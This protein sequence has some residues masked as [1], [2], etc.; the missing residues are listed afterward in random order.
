MK[1]YKHATEVQTLIFD[2][3]LYT[4]KR[5]KAW[6]R[7]HKFCYGS[8][9]EKPNTIRLRQHDPS[10]YRPSTFRTI[11]LG[12]GGVRA[13]VGVPLRAAAAT[14]PAGYDSRGPRANPHV[15]TSRA[16]GIVKLAAKGARLK[17]IKSWL[18]LDERGTWEQAARKMVESTAERAAELNLTDA[19]VDEQIAIMLRLQATEAMLRDAKK[20][21]GKR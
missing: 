21:E 9:D 8:V 12:D 16:R 4:V 6:A 15:F 10:E 20:R 18:T 5:A 1:P 11:T 14:R 3:D 17:S 13:V 19:Q 2:A 7:A